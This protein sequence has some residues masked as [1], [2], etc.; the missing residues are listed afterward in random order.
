[1]P[2]NGGEELSRP[3]L[4]VVSSYPPPPCET[5]AINLVDD[6]LTRHLRV[7]SSLPTLDMTPP[8]PPPGYQAIPAPTG[9]LRPST[10]RAVKEDLLLSPDTIAREN[11]E[12]CSV[13]LGGGGGGNSFDGRS[14]A[15]IRPQLDEE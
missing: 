10:E 14:A 12:N 5:A 8:L 2:K 15:Q 6:I 13:F 4:M 11:V 1:M 3:L 9:A 7:G